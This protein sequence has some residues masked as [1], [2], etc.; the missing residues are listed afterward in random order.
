MSLFP[1]SQG[2]GQALVWAGVET[3]AAR[4][5]RDPWE[6]IV[7]SDQH[8]QTAAPDGSW[9]DSGV[10]KGCFWTIKHTL[11]WK[12]NIHIYWV[13][14][15]KISLNIVIIQIHPVSVKIQVEMDFATEIK[16][17]HTRQP[18]EALQFRP[19]WWEAL[20]LRE[21][22]V[23]VRKREGILSLGLPLFAAGIPHE[24]SFSSMILFSCSQHILSLPLTVAV[25]SP[26]ESVA[27]PLGE[28]HMWL[29]ELLK[30]TKAYSF[31][32]NLPQ[33]TT[34]QL[35]IPSVGRGRG[36]KASWQC[37]LTLSILSPEESV[38]LP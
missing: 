33:A 21:L 17:D 3:E 10:S 25:L 37:S 16:C 14:C 12:S 8:I 36:T 30:L 18:R 2:L 24:C 5:G 27:R 6:T 20:S 23:A 7:L 4:P 29:H 13:S 9:G 35:W 32:I 1:W 19:Q 38:A 31:P 15:S 28:K 11:F 34:Q 26:L 22:G